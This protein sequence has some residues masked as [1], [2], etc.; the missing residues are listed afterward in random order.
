MIQTDRQYIK[1]SLYGFLKNLKFYE[2]F[3]ILFFLGNHLSYFQIGLLYSIREIVQ[4]IFEIPSGMIADS[5]GRRRSLA[6]SFL[7]YIISFIVFYLSTSF[8]WFVFAMFFFGWAEA[9]RT[10]TNKAM[11]YTYLNWH[12]LSNQKVHY[13]GHTRSW[14]Q[15]GSAVGSLSAGILVAFTQNYRMI[16]LL[17]AIPYLLDFL[18]ILS[19]PHELDGKK[20]Q[21][22]WKII[23]EK[24][25]T[26]YKGFMISIKN[27]LVI[28]IVLNSAV[29]SAY[30]KGMKDFVQPII[31]T[32]AMGI[33][34]LLM[35]EG[36]QRSAIL[37]G[38]VYAFIY[39]L[40]SIASRHSKKISA[41]FKNHYK[42][43]N[44]TLFIGITAGI[45]SGV[46]FHLEWE[47][48]SIVAFIF[49]YFVQNIRKPVSSAL[50]AD[51]VQKE[52][53]ASALS[54][55]NQLRT[56]I[57][58]FITPVFGYLSDQF[59]LGAGLIIISFIL[60]L[61]SPLYYSKAK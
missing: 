7:L 33:P 1:F 35:L 26:V 61:F 49:I 45:L 57:I 53:Y 25:K 43:L 51:L 54:V 44:Y 27:I 31:K 28:R 20:Y 10:G 32:F 42:A 60:L 55:D 8:S 19:Y 38:L 22:S 56:I 4:N 58:A 37:V 46:F 48:V 29:Y 40:S 52:V 23:K 21:A 5:Y 6:F 17:S 41:L 36:K 59:G 15:I 3:I 9:F 16:F 18:L 39:V 50:T 11:I 2:P 13:Y 47:S 24:F 12:G 34:A 30:Y 14:S